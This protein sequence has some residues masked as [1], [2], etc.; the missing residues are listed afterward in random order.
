MAEAARRALEVDGRFSADQQ[1]ERYLGA[2]RTLLA[3]KGI[4]L[5]SL[6]SHLETREEVSAS[7]RVS[8]LERT[9]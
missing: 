2:Y 5:P 3:R 6:D 1:V 9:A 7:R 8:R 4:V